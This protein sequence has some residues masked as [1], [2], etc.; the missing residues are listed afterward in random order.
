PE[1]SLPELAKRDDIGLAFSGGGTRSA[2]MTLGQLRGL[3]RLGWLE[4]V[5]Y[6]SA[7]SGGGWAAIPF[8]FSTRSLDELLGPYV[9]PT[10]LTLLLVNGPAMGALGVAISNSSL[11]SGA[12]REGPAE[13]LAILGRQPGVSN[14]LLSH[15]VQLTNRLRREGERDDKTYARLLGR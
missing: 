15:L 11:L 9:A 2:T 14:P 4:R 6:V 7:I 8:T 1:D 3:Q 5:R 12:G 13:Y 10:D